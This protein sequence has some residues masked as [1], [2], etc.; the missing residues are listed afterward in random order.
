[1]LEHEQ[2]LIREGKTIGLEFTDNK[3]E[4]NFLSMLERKNRLDETL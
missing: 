3:T 1:M 4:T 2:D